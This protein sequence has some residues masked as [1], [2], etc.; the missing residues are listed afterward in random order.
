MESSNANIVESTGP[1]A[2]PFVVDALLML[3]GLLIVELAMRE[4]DVWDIGAVYE[5][6][7]G[8]GGAMRGEGLG[9]APRV[10]TL[11]GV[12]LRHTAQCKRAVLSYQI[13]GLHT[14]SDT[15]RCLLKTTL[16]ERTASRSFEHATG[17]KYGERSV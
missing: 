14:G 6:D 13:T 8:R 7:S 2:A 17:H 10:E 3:A 15:P 1:D 16:R 5:P 11:E 12:W 9:E 4:R